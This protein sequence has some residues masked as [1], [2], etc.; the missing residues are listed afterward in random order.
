MGIHIWVTD[1]ALRISSRII[2]RYA[3]N[4]HHTPFRITVL[5]IQTTLFSTFTMNDFSA[6]L[7]GKPKLQ[8][9]WPEHVNLPFLNTVPHRYRI[10]RRRTKSKSRPGNEEIT[11]LKTS[12][13]A[14]DGVRDLQK[15]HWRTSDLQ[16]AVVGL[17]ILFS[18][19]IAPPAPG[20]KLLAIIGSVWILL[21]PATRQFFLPSV[22]IW[23]WLLYFF[24]SR[25]VLI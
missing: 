11:S 24:C 12:F 22:T 6:T 5:S 3:T 7:S 25:Y 19:W 1:Y 21:M 15:H 10:G 18:F 17:L 20:V 16:Y 23:T 14:W 9:L 13:N 4:N 8:L 2:L